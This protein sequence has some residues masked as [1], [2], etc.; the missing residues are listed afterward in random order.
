MNEDN[1][2]EWINSIW[3]KEWLKLARNKKY[4]YELN[5]FYVKVLDYTF[6]DSMQ[7][8]KDQYQ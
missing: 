4:Y 6:V 5:K 2:E 3:F 7:K 1:E 8:D